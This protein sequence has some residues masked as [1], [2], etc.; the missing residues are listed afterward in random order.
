MGNWLQ[1]DVF[2][3]KP[4][5]FRRFVCMVALKF[6]RYVKSETAALVLEDKDRGN[7]EVRKAALILS[8]A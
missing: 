8:W 5:K 1:C 3:T 6:A 4:V 7:A 2:V